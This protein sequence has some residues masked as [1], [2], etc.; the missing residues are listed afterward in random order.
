M[1]DLQTDPIERLKIIIK[2][3]DKEIEELE[4]ILEDKV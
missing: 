1:N 4:Y 2:N 3:I